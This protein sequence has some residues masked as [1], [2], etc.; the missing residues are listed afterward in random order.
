VWRIGTIAVKGTFESRVQLRRLVIGLLRSRC[1]K[2]GC[3]E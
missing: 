1:Y 2:G 3:H